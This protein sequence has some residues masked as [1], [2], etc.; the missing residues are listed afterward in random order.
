M[1]T[2][3]GPTSPAPPSSRDDVDVRAGAA[4]RGWK[5]RGGSATVATSAAN[6]ASSATARHPLLWYARWCA[7]GRCHFRGAPPSGTLFGRRRSLTLGVELVSAVLRSVSTRA[8]PHEHSLHFVGA[9]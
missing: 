8:L 6:C 3:P 5:A 1:R 7:R 2:Y 4:T 9:T